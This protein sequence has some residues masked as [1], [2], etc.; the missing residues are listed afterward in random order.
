MEDKPYEDSR[1]YHFSKVFRDLTIKDIL[2][3]L[4]QS[5]RPIS[6]PSI[7]WHRRGGQL[8]DRPLWVLEATRPT[9][10]VHVLRGT[11]SCLCWVRPRAKKGSAA[12]PGCRASSP[13]SGAIWPRG[14]HGVGDRK[15]SCC[16]GWE[17]RPLFLVLLLISSFFVPLFISIINLNCTFMYSSVTCRPPTSLP[18]LKIKY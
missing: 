1:I 10:S 2:G 9:V 11:E 7:P 15:T 16:G 14:P 3:K 6:V 18:T 12:G 4:F 5:K 8:A 17:S 13:A